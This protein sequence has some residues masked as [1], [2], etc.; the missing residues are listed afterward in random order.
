MPPEQD[1]LIYQRQVQTQKLSQTS[2]ICSFS[3]IP[4]HDFHGI[5]RDKVHEQKDESDYTDNDWNN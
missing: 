4:Q 3:G 5:T 2:F 1:V